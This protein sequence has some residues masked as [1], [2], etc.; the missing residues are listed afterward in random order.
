[1][2]FARLDGQLGQDL[3]ANFSR[4]IG[5]VAY[6]CRP[7]TPFTQEWYAELLHRWIFMQIN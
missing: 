7:N 5:N 2:T 3:K 1:M 4:I 6:I